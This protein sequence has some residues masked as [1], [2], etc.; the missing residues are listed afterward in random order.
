MRVISIGETLWDVFPGGEHL[1]GAPLNLA[2]HLARLGHASALVTTVGRDERG[3][4][5]LRLARKGGIDLRFVERSARLPTGVVQVQ[6]TRERGPAYRIERPAAYDDTILTAAQIAAIAE[7]QPDWLCYGTLFHREAAVLDSTRRLIEGLPEVS[8]FYD[9]NLRDGQQDAPLVRT[10]AEWAHIVKFSAEEA[11][12]FAALLDLPH[13]TPVGLLQAL[14]DRYGYRAVVMTRGA[15]GCLIRVA[16]GEGAECPAAPVMVADPV[17]AGDAF[18]AAFLHGWWQR[19]P[20]AEIGSFA[21]RIGG[22]VASRPGATP[23]WSMADV[24]GNA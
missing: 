16:G 2:F 24:A 8:R 12:A 1:G 22:L 9:V 13:D 19:W 18:A 7:W 20:L 23:F 5:A 14:L 10:L 3:D 6:V 11:E 4:E 21:N 17:G 15:Q